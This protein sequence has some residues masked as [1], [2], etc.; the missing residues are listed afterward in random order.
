MKLASSVSPSLGLSTSVTCL[1]LIKPSWGPISNSCQSTGIL[2]STVTR[3]LGSLPGPVVN[4]LINYGD[5]NSLML[6]GVETGVTHDTSPSV[7]EILLLYDDIIV[8]LEISL[9]HRLS[10]ILVK[11]V[12]NKCLGVGCVSCTQALSG[13]LLTSTT[14]CHI[15]GLSWCL[16]SRLASAARPVNV[17][18][19]IEESD[20]IRDEQINPAHDFT[21]VLVSGCVDCLI[22]TD[23]SD[24]LIMILPMYNCPDLHRPVVVLKQLFWLLSEFIYWI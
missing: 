14:W 3:G 9:S 16:L 20:H 10:H 21:I 17:N 18:I 8:Y 24:H 7:T 12:L 15:T 13:R 19:Y 1:G 22:A 6:L 23:V 4:H 2:S 11:V 5:S